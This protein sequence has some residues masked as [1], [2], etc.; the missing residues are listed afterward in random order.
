MMVPTASDVCF[1]WGAKTYN[2][3]GNVRFRA[4]ADLSR[5]EYLRASMAQKANIVK[6]LRASVEY[7]GGRWLVKEGGVWQE[8]HDA[9]KIN[10]K[11]SQ[12][13]RDGLT[14]E[15]KKDKRHFYKLEKALKN[16]KIDPSELT[17][18]QQNMRRRFLERHPNVHSPFPVATVPGP[19]VVEQQAEEVPY[20]GPEFDSIPLSKMLDH[21]EDSVRE[22]ELAEAAQYWLSGSSPTHVPLN[23]I[24][25]PERYS[26]GDTELT[27]DD[28]EQF[29]LNVWIGEA[30]QQYFGGTHV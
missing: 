23:V 1:G 2:H 21:K 28:A 7:R 5:D 8:T 29:Q 12:L 18:D 11:C 13:L 20:L 30:Q 17:V 26:G 19:Q 25:D 9:A 14:R 3:E 4:D 22:V 10:E 24:Q 6:Q 15:E 27:E 16:E